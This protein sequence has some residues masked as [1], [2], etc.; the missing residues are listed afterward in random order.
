MPAGDTVNWQIARDGVYAA[1]GE[2]RSVVLRRVP[3]TGGASTRVAELP[4]YSWPGFS[5]TPDGAHVLYARWDRRESN[6]MAIE[7]R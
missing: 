6:I 2:G 3:L 4:Q 5:L 1:A 7:V